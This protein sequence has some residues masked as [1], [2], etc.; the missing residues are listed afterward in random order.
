MKLRIKNN[1]E[2]IMH[3]SGI[4]SFQM[5][6]DRLKANQNFVL[7]R[8]TI[9]RLARNENASYSI[10]LIESLCNELQCL[11]ADIFDTTVEG[12]S[13]EFVKSLQSRLQPFRYGQILVESKE[14][15]GI[16]QGSR[17]KLDEPEQTSTLADDFDDI[18]GP[19]VSH[20]TKDD[21]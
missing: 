6:S 12:A 16:E 4:K 18:C 1:L 19:S 21:L 17:P 20:L 11:P 8:S 15:Q 13:L 7:G 14:N 10:E 2:I 3:D 5:L 9:S